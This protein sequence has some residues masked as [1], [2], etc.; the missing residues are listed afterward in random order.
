ME[1]YSLLIVNCDVDPSPVREVADAYLSGHQHAP[2]LRLSQDR[3]ALH[4]YN[5]TS[6]LLV[7][8]Y[9][10]LGFGILQYLSLGP[11]VRRQSRGVDKSAR[12]L[13]LILA[14]CVIREILAWLL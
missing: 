5:S 1:T 6:C 3:L 13:D 9:L 2:P 8:K 11:R 10:S 12:V 14:S 7:E 4:W